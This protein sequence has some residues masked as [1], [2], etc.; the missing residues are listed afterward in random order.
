MSEL[1]AKNVNM[2][3][4]PSE[5]RDEWLR[6][7]EACKDMGILLCFYFCRWKNH[8]FI[9]VSFPFFLQILAIG[10]SDPCQRA[11]ELIICFSKNNDQFMFP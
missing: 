10:S 9:N 8:L 7:I 11:Y 1:A 3:L 5:L 4:P 6:G 2:F